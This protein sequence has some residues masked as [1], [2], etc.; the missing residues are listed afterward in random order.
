MSPD[1]QAC[2]AMALQLPTADRALLAE[3]LLDSLAPGESDAEVERL[4]VIEAN[5]RYDDYR[6]GR[7][8]SMSADEAMRLACQT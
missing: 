2:E 5:R 8:A 6:A 7:M 1:L 4:W 3:H